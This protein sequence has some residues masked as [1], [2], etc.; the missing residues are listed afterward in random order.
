MA[1]RWVKRLGGELLGGIQLGVFALLGAKTPLW[2]EQEFGA[3]LY[4]IRRCW[5][6][7]EDSALVAGGI[8]N[9]DH[10]VLC[11]MVYLPVT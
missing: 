7:C 4:Y 1:I 8:P 5:C 9:T 3:L 6:N 2:L 11:S 10:C